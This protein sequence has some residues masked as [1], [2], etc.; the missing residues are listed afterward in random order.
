MRLA[1]I[2]VARMRAA[3]DSPIMAGFMAAVDP[4][5]RM[6]ESSPGFVWRLRDAGGHMP[7]CLDEARHWQVVNV[8]VWESYEALHEFVYRSQHG[9]LIRRRAEWFLPTP[10]PSTAL[11]WVPDDHRPALDHSRARLT[12]LRREGPS[13]RAFSVRRRFEPDGTPR[14]RR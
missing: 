7:T 2:N 5:Y 8:S 3:P 10:Q 14:R 11:W 6:A 13:P 9:G 4:I 1:Q 12:V